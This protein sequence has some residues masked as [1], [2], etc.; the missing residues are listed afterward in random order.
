[1]N[2][3]TYGHGWYNTNASSENMTLT[4][5]RLT[6]A[7]KTYLESTADMVYR[8]YV[9]V[10][11]K[12]I[13]VNGGVKYEG[14]I[15]RVKNGISYLS[16][17]KPPADPRRPAPKVPPEDTV[18]LIAKRPAAE[19]KAPAP[20]AAAQPQTPAPPAAAE[21]KAPAPPEAAGKRVRL[22][23]TVPATQRKDDPRMVPLL[24]LLPLNTA[25]ERL[26]PMGK[27]GGVPDLEA[28]DVSGEGNPVLDIVQDLLAGDGPALLEQ[29]TCS[30]CSPW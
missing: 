13:G 1:M 8:I 18:A 19:P 23:P 28:P 25:S 26:Y 15:V 9:A 5:G 3:F 17:Q 11:D 21:P 12:S 10:Q 29:H 16:L 14:V 2:D 22:V 30:T 4:A 24:P 7:T 20:Q 27:D 6:Q